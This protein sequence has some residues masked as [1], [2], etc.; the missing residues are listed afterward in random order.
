MNEMNV[1]KS[2]KSVYVQCFSLIPRLL[3]KKNNLATYPSSAA[4]KC[5]LPIRF[6]VIFVEFQLHH[7]YITVKS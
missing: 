3:K 2:H 5:A 1:E 4:L 7:N 6:Q